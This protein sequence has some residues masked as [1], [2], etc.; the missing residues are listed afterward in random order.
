MVIYR[1]RLQYVQPE[2]FGEQF[3]ILK[4]NNLYTDSIGFSPEGGL[5]IISGEDCVW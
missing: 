2:R 5:L 4:S 1:A 3:L